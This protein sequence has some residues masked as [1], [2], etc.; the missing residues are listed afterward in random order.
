MG[1]RIYR[2]FQNEI[3]E[4][5]SKIIDNQALIIL[6]NNQTII[7]K[8]IEIG[9][10][11]IVISNRHSKLKQIFISDIQEIEIDKTTEW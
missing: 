8:I 7:G 11:T 4:K 2:Y 9:N 3:L 6:K 1:K 5:I 10:Q